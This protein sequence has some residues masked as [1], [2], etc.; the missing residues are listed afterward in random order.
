MQTILSSTGPISLVV[1]DDL[2]GQELSVALRIAHDLHTYHRLDSQI[3][4]S[5]EAF[6]PDILDGGNIVV[7]GNQATLAFTKLHS[8]KVITSLPAITR[9]GS[10]N[11]VLYARPSRNS[12][13]PVNVFTRNNV[14]AFS[15]D[16]PGGENGVYPVYRP[17]WAG[18]GGA[19]ISDTHWCYCARLDNR[20]GAGGPDWSCWSTRSRVRHLF[21]RCCT[22]NRHDV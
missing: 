18:E 6:D 16:P 22:S 8:S 2:D 11:P 15:S 17:C 3:V 19:T 9:P 21:L 7:I 5:S 10:G 4:R 20:W 14:H 12:A 13:K 1:P